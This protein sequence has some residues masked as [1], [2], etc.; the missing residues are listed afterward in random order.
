MRRESGLGAW[1]IERFASRA[2]AAELLARRL[3][4]YRGRNPLV[5]GIPR[6]AVPM[7]KAIAV[8]LGGELDVVLVHKLGA[9]YQPEFAIGAVSETG[10]VLLSDAL[11]LYGL[12][13]GYVESEVKRELDRL[14]RRRAAYTPV[15]PP[16]D[17]ANRIVIVVDD[18]GATGS[19]MLAALRAV[20]ARNPATLVAATAVAPPEAVAR[21]KGEADEVI[22]LEMPSRFFAV[23]QYFADFR[24]VTDEEV[25]AALAHSRLRPTP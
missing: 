12:E 15:R 17:A 10:E 6:G 5:L 25:V 11:E 9:P 20:R 18:G 4:E 3:Q 22:V 2:E 23:S 7:A 8:A 21:M 24:E 16:I 1:S 14:R 13:R 19:T